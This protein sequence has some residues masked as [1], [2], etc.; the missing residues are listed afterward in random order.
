MKK[1][2][3]LIL[4][5]LA[6]SAVFAGTAVE[7]NATTKQMVVKTTDTALLTENV[8]INLSTGVQAGVNVDND[9]ISLSTCHASGRTSSRE[10]A[11]VTCVAG[12]NPG[13]PQVCTEDV[14]KVMETKSGAVMNTATTRAGTVSPVYPNVP[15]NTANAAGAA[16]T[17]L[18]ADN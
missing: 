16:G 8:T 9:E 10:V 5:M 4:S 17:R 3:V 12:A 7:M 2:T 6:S 1:I 18:T 15:C 13:D 14:P 11:K